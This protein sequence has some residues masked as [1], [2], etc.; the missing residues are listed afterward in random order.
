M[1]SF[2]TFFCA[3]GLEEKKI[4]SGDEPTPAHA[5]PA[6]TAPQPLCVSH[7]RADAG[8]VADDAAD[9]DVASS[10]HDQ[11]VHGQKCSGE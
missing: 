4:V 1:A 10:N 7:A 8:S 9:A 2:F 6:Y 3:T 5:G 11:H